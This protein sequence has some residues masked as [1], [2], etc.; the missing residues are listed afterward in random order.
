MQRLIVHPKNGNMGKTFLSH[1]YLPQIPPTESLPKY[2]SCCTAGMPE[3]VC[4]CCSRS[5]DLGR[6]DY[7]IICIRLMLKVRGTPKWTSLK[8][9][10]S[11]SSW[12]GLDTKWFFSSPNIFLTEFQA[13]NIRQNSPFIN[14]HWCHCFGTGETKSLLENHSDL[15]PCSSLFMV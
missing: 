4:T 5:V 15:L 3:Y 8:S 2:F 11:D 1:A 12:N 10:F 6:I 7:S 13:P 14:Q 9:I